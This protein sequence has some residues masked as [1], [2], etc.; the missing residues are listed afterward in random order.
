MTDG[1]RPRLRI[2]VAD[3]DTPRRSQVANTLAGLG[4]D[5]LDRASELSELGV[6]TAQERPDVAVVIVGD[7]SE[8]ALE[9]IGRI[10][11]EAACPVIAILDVEDPAFVRKAAA[12]GIFAYLSGEEAESFQS[13]I[14]VVLRRFAEY[15]DLEGAFGRRAV[16]ERAKGILMERYSIGERD[17][18]EML[19][20]HAR[21]SGRKIVDVAEAI[22]AS[23]R[24]LP[25]E[26]SRAAPSQPLAPPP[27]AD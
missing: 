3:G 21:G 13:S 5:V 17:A 2:L 27:Q 1:D 10:V 11:R 19:R 26:A 7:A 9:I 24:L 16:T 8:R 12:R 22:L 4:H 15:H 23:H 14:D 20:S 18:F 25:G 6:V